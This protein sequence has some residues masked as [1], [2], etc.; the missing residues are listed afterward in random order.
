MKQIEIE[1]KTSDFHWPFRLTQTDT[2]DFEM[3]SKRNR[4][5]R[6]DWEAKRKISERRKSKQQ[7]KWKVKRKTCA[8]KRSRTWNECAEQVNRNLLPSSHSMLIFN[9]K[10]KDGKSW[11]CREHL[12]VKKMREKRKTERQTSILSVEIGEVKTRDECFSLVLSTWTWKK[13]Q[14][15]DSK[16]EVWGKTHRD[17][18]T[19]L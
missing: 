9:G 18:Q 2:I 12:K 13:V 6:Y 19:M 1:T 5:V 7:S 15:R 4:F 17:E 3:E 10:Q 8:W 16:Y 14:E 11:C